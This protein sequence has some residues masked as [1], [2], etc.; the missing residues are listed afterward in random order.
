MVD[1]LAEFFHFAAKRS[2]LFPQFADQAADLAEDV[3]APGGTFAL[4]GRFAFSG[5]HGLFPILSPFTF[6]G[7]HTLVPSLVLFALTLNLTF[8]F[9][10]LLHGRL[11]GIAF[12]RFAKFRRM[13]PK[14]FKPLHH[15][16]DL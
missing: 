7:L 3:I 11:G 10:Y 9:T 12:P 15:P 4:G 5:D 13:G 2:D 1:L 16:T 8:Q 6:A 14:L